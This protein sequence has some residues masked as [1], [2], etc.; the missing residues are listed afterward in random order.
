MSITRRSILLLRPRCRCRW[1]PYDSVDY[2]RAPLSEISELSS[3]W[4]LQA[5]GIGHQLRCVIMLCDT[6]SF[7]FES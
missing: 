5:I 7:V 3:Q 2:I 4:E 6:F 1:C